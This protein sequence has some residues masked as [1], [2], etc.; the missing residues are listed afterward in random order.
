MNRY[1]DITECSAITGLTHNRSPTVSL[2][3]ISIDKLSVFWSEMTALW[4]NFTMIPWIPSLP[5]RCFCKKNMPM[6]GYKITISAFLE[7]SLGSLFSTLPVWQICVMWPSYMWVNLWV[8]LSASQYRPCY[9]RTP[10]ICKQCVYCFTI[11][12]CSG[13]MGSLNDVTCLYLISIVM[14]SRDCGSNITDRFSLS[15]SYMIQH[16]FKV[17]FRGKWHLLKASQI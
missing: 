3:N 14:S 2:W 6:V 9:R 10:H 13:H 1:Y 5:Q 16:I 12:H 7:V 8:N 11:M 15:W 4:W 17:F